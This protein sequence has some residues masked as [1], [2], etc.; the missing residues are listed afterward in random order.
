MKLKLIHL[1]VAVLVICAGIFLYQKLAPGHQ[2]ESSAAEK[3]RLEE[4]YGSKL[5]SQHN[6]EYII[7]DFFQDQKEGFFV[8]VGASHYRTNSTT[9]YLE[10]HLGWSGIAVD[11]LAK[12]AVGYQKNRINTQFYCFF[13]SDHSDEEA[14]FFINKQ[15]DRVS[16]GDRGFAERH[17]E[18]DEVRIAT[19]TLNDLLWHSQVDMIDFLS[20][21][22]ELAEPAALAGFDIQKYR[23][24]LV[25]IEAHAQVRDQIVG[26]FTKNNYRIIEKYRD[27]DSLNLYF[28]P[29]EN[30]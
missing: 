18:Y 23:P 11:A 16:S 29:Q 17:G 10:R 27:L 12:F 15:N 25:C 5:Y 26:Y 22:I 14:V 3:N 8:D 13:V 20:M 4:K 6:E 19:I 24:R 9:Y 28:T 30:R 1:L 21:D 2:L 7:R